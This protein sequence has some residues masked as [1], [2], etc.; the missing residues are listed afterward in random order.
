MNDKDNIKKKTKAN[1]RRLSN[2]GIVIISVIGLF[3]ICIVISLLIFFDIMHN[4][5]YETS[6]P[7]QSQVIETITLPPTA[8]NSSEPIES[9]IPEYPSPYKS[10]DDI[11]YVLLFGLAEYDLADA[12]WIAII[13]RTDNTLDFLSIPR[14]TW[15]RYSDRNKFE[16]WKIN[17]YYNIFDND[18]LIES[19][20][21]TS[22]MQLLG[23]C[24][25]LLDIDMDYY[26]RISYDTVQK[27]VD[28]MGGI[29]YDVPFG[30]YYYDFTQDLVIEIDKGLQVLDGEQVVKFLRYRQGVGYEYTSDI[31]RIDRQQSMIKAIIKK[32]LNLSNISSVIDVA[33]N[34][35][36]TN[37]GKEKLTSYIS[38]ALTLNSD[39]IDTGNILVGYEDS[40]FVGQKD[41]EG[42]DKPTSYY[43]TNPVDIREQLI[44][45]CE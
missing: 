16:H 36:R 40:I 26:V 8:T 19:T 39:S 31:E 43:F 1:T 42:N 27:I 5:I 9:D 24:E 28:S 37:I 10:E 38:F 2:K 20:S 44:A 7:T 6:S 14:D 23:A 41:S 34:N 18:V 25:T 3:L 35:I 33:K 4:S 17:S 32:A 12:I 45:I 13:N 30:M 22:S 15:L 21:S 29:E 11:E